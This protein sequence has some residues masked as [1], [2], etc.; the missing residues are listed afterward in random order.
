MAETEWWDLPLVPAAAGVAGV[1]DRSRFLRL[2]RAPRGGRA[3]G[4]V[5]VLHGGVDR[6]SR[7]EDGHWRHMRMTNRLTFVHA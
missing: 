1:E 3:H 2:H 5:V 6:S 4:T 7:L